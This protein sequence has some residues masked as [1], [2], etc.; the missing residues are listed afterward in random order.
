MATFRAS[1]RVGETTVSCRKMS[2]WPVAGVSSMTCGDWVPFFSLSIV[3][4][5]WGVIVPLEEVQELMSTMLALGA[6][7]VPF[8]SF[9]QRFLSDHFPVGVSSQRTNMHRATAV[10]MMNGMT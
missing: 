2:I 3:A 6:E 7:V 9:A 5:L 8:E 4:A 10:M 1:R